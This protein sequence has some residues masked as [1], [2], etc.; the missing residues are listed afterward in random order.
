M[1]VL[2]IF[3]ALLVFSGLSNA[4]TTEQN[5]QYLESGCS[6]EIS[7]AG[8]SFSANTI[9]SAL[10]DFSRATDS[11]TLGYFSSGSEMGS[12]P[13]AYDRLVVCLAQRRLDQINGRPIA[14]GSA[15]NN[16]GKSKSDSNMSKCV[17]TQTDK[18]GGRLLNTC[19]EPI[20]VAYCYLDGSLASYICKK[21]KAGVWSKG[22]KDISPGG[23]G[24]LPGAGPN[25]GRVNIRW[26]A[27]IKGQIPQ[28]MGFDQSGTPK[29]RCK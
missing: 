11:T 29:G 3:V 5:I 10:S 4:Q 17:R 16:D 22:S 1:N 14:K 26:Y 18:N 13:N 15:K 24:L 9:S 20:S 19:Q 21:D 6:R 23:Y 28:I 27:C 12:P 25:S 2:F 7:E 8:A